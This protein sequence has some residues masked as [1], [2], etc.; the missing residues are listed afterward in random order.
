MSSERRFSE[1]LAK[2]KF[3]AWGCPVN[4]NEAEIFLLSCLA[5]RSLTGYGPQQCRA[6]YINV[7]NSICSLVAYVVYQTNYLCGFLH[8]ITSSIACS[9]SRW[10]LIY[11]EFDFEV[12]RPAGATHCTDGVKFGVD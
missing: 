2:Q 3:S 5:N 4:P 11:S 1:R 10:Y 9:A 7:S 8:I 6:A 12:S